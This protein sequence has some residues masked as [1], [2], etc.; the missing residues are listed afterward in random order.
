MDLLIFWDA[1]APSGIQA[2]LSRELEVLLPL[3]PA[4]CESHFVVTGYIPSR[5][6][7]DASV[8]LDSLDLYK[9][10]TGISHPILLVVSEDLCRSG[11]EYLFGLSRESTGSAVVSTARLENE[12]YGLPEDDEDLIDRLVKESAH[13]VG[14]LL[15][16][17]HCRN[18]ECI[19]YNPL[20]L[21]DINRQKRWFCPECRVFTG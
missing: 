16:L 19:M 9:K 5:R 12:Y 11:D 21:D 2:A 15:G 13:E 3:T 10:R 17:R 4:V 14:H 6:Q 20:V 1:R 7:T 18:S 8:L